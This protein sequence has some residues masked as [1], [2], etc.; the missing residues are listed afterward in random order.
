MPLMAAEVP[1]MICLLD[2]TAYWIGKGLASS[3]Q[4]MQHYGSHA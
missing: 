4:A 2:R 3:E 1:E